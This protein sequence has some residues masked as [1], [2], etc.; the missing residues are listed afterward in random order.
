MCLRLCVCEQPF[1]NSAQSFS[2]LRR[3]ISVRLLEE[4]L[5]MC[6]SLFH[7]KELYILHN[8]K[9]QKKENIYKEI[10]ENFCAI[11]EEKTKWKIK[12]N[13]E[14]AKKKEDIFR[15][16]N[17]FFAALF[18]VSLSLSSSMHCIRS[19]LLV[20]V[21][22]CENTLHIFFELFSFLVNEYL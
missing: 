21:N 10:K 1:V 22:Y 5:S 3:N 13:K 15:L 7:K 8:G 17:N 16:R 20:T 11:H 14:K 18:F 9:P 6:S 19:I 12:L 2:L 4:L